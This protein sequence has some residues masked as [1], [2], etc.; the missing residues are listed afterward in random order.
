MFHVN[1]CLAEDSHE[2]SGLIF[3]VKQGKIFKKAIYCTRG[4]RFKG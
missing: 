2:I 1:A 3:S 4:C